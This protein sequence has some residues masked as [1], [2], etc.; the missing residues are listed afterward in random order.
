MTKPSV[1]SI[2]VVEDDPIY[3]AVLAHYLSLN[4]DYQVKRFENAASF[5]ACIHEQPDIITLDYNLPD[6]NG[7]ELLEKIQTLT[8]SSGVIVISGQDNVQVAIDLMKKGVNDYIVKSSDTNEKL[9]LSIQKLRENVSLKKQVSS[10]QKEVERKYAFSNT[11]IGKSPALKHVFNLMEKATKTNINILVTGETGTGKELV[12][13]SIHFNSSRKNEPFIPVNVTAIPRELIESE[14]FGHEKG[15][16]TGANNRRIG[17]FEEASKGTIFLDE[18]AEMDINLQAKLL[19]VLQEKELCRVGGNEV[20]KIDVRIIVATHKHLLDEVNKGKFR[21]DLYY[22]LLGLPI[23]LPALRERGNDIVL[24]AKHCIDNF[25]AE[26]NLSEKSLSTEAKKKLLMHP[27][28]GN[29]RQLK[30][31][32]EL[33]CIMCEGDEIQAENLQEM[34]VGNGTLG[35][36]INTE[37]LTLRQYTI[38]LVQHYLNSN[39]FDVMEVARKLDMGKSTIYRMINNNEL[40]LY[41]V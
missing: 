34:Q 18:I 20:I 37:N 36:P 33:A 17:K 25:C 29:V 8:P 39:D 22:R 3:G 6:A 14:L 9:W 10:L 19:R 11:I 15:A 5:L 23:Y 35:I 30:A 16:F 28:P 1:L 38:K 21:E 26:N 41:T 2:F 24:I 32:V 40:V 27:F 12:A 4:P 31:L 7:D 13:K